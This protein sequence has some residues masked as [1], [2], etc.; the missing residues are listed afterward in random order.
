VSPSSATAGGSD[1]TITVTGTNLTAG[2]I[3]KFNGTALTTDAT[4]A[5]SG[6]LT[7]IVPAGSIVTPGSYPVTVTTSSGTSNALNVTVGGIYYSKAT[8]DL[9]VLATFGANSDGSG[10]APTS[11]TT[12]N[13]V[14]NVSGTG[15][16]IGAAWTVAGTGSKVVLASNAS[17]T[18][19]AAFNFTGTL[20]LAAGATLTQLNAAPAVTFGTL[21]VTS[22]VEYAQAGTYALAAFPVIGY[23]NLTLRNATKT[24]PNGTANI[25][26]GNLVVDNVANFG[27]Y[28][29]TT[30]SL[31][32]TLSLGGNLTLSGTVTF[33]APGKITLLTTN[34]TDQQIFQGNGNL[35]QLFRLTT[36][37]AAAG[38][39][40]TPGVVLMGNTTPIE[41]GN[42]AGGGYLLGANTTL[43]VN[44]NALSFFTNGKASIQ[45]TGTLAASSG[46]S[47]S[48][49]RS[50]GNSTN[51]GTLRLVPAAT[52][53]IS[54]FTLNAQGLSATAFDSLAVSGTLVVNG[55]ATLTR[56]HVFI[57]AGSSVTLGGP[58]SIANSASSLLGS[59]IGGTG[60]ST[61]V[62]SGTGAVDTLAFARGAA[63]L[64]NLTFN[65]SDVPTIRIATEVR[66]NGTLTLTAGR[67]EMLPTTPTAALPNNTFRIYLGDTGGVVGGGSDSYTNALT[68]AAVT[69]NTTPTATLNFPLGKGGQ[70]RP[71]TLSVNQDIGT[72]YYTARQFEGAPPARGLSAA[73][74][75]NTAPPMSTTPLTRVSQIRYFNVSPEPVVVGYTP[76]TF[77]SA[78][79]TLSYVPANDRT[80]NDDSLRVA[81]SSS[82]SS[83]W[84]SIGGTG[85]GSSIMSGAFT[86]FSDFVL[87]TVARLTTN[88]PLPV[89]LTRFTAT[90]GKGGVTLN[91]ATASEKNSA[92]FEVQRRG[93]GN[94]DTF[95]TIA[96]V[97]AYG[98]TTAPQTYAALDESLSDGTVYYRLKQVDRDGS[99]HYSDVVTVKA[100]AAGSVVTAPLSFYPNPATDVV[101]VSNASLSGQAVSIRDLMGREVRRTTVAADGQV[102]LRD[103]PAGTYLLQVRDGAALTTRRIVKQ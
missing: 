56:G 55:T 40:P 42:A 20:D 97:A 79:I 12:N 1:F 31:F 29:G 71:V 25:V 74:V 4:N 90:R 43:F 11:F 88:N 61:L 98:N 26:R 2:S 5:A 58:F 6:T 62:L 67:V 7:A 72:T 37:A 76:P 85:N 60:T 19:P 49:S 100:A 63:L 53:S 16:T 65:R 78:N 94:A 9:N 30:S 57:N 33:D 13:T 39:L 45:G 75:T 84:E 17:F 83:N 99:V 66:V 3:V 101:T 22:T 36:T 69:N 64:G 21:D 80:N 47:L 15:R 48:F 23:G 28:N 32:T 52:T 50:S 89:E 38:V 68:R 77:N 27:G 51:I 24:L 35:L 46:A 18:V 59:P 41:L 82:P 81:K 95:S 8:G 54:S 93:D 86:S 14:F 91:W 103:L 70:Y 73:T 10:T 102:S 96:K 87:A 92:Y 44:N 34:T